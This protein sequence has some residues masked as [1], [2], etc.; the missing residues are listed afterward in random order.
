MDSGRQ[1]YA[2]GLAIEKVRLPNLVLERETAKSDLVADCSFWS[3]VDTGSVRRQ[4]NLGL[5]R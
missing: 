3:T 5:I 4:Q 1:F 2:S